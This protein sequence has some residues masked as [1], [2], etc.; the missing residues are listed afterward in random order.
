M[1]GVGLSAILNSHDSVCVDIALESG[2]KV[3]ALEYG[4]S[5]ENKFPFALNQCA[6]VFS[7]V[8]Q[9]SNYFNVDPKFSL[10]RRRFCR[11]EFSFG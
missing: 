11:W 10:Y 5:P 1:E 3:I 4:L 8:H 9:N 7:Y 6:W 2:T